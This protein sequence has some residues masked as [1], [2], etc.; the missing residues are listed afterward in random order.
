MLTKYLSASFLTDRPSSSSEPQS[1][2]D[3]THET[4]H[5]KVQSSP[6]ISYNKETSF[7]ICHHWGQSVTSHVMITVLSSHIPNCS[8][9][10]MIIS[11]FAQ[12]EIVQCSPQSIHKRSILLGQISIKLYP[13]FQVFCKLFPYLIVYV[14]VD[15]SST[16]SLSAIFSNRHPGIHGTDTCALFTSEIIFH[17]I[18]HTEYLKITLFM[19]SASLGHCLTNQVNMISTCSQTFNGLVLVK[20]YFQSS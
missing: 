5:V 19:I 17:S 10:S 2:I 11:Q 4:D 16:V 12:V 8:S 15:R 7:C 18:S 1:T 20:T 3:F 6:S 9:I 13:L 14:I